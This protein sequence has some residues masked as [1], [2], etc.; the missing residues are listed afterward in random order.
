MAELIESPLKVAEDHYLLRIKLDKKLHALPGQFINIR[1]SDSTDPL[2]RRPF[3]IFNQNEEILE[4]IIQVVGRGTTLLAGR[5]KGPIDI[6]GPLGK[7]FTLLE[8]GSAL[9]V[10]GGVGNAPLY[11][12]ARALKDRGVSVTCLYGA[13]AKKYI[14]CAKNFG[15]TADIFKVATDDGSTGH[16]GFITE[17]MQ[18]MLKESSY[19]M[20]YTCGPTPMMA[21][22]AGLCEG[23]IPLEVSLENYFGCGIGLCAGCTVE[24]DDGFKRAC[25]DGPVM[26]GSYL[27]WETLSH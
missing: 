14:Y 2:V 5:E 18:E 26:D 10:G 12:L 4:I 23:R 25:I 3:S 6:L 1:I 11:Y 16:R 27:K 22:V 9:L 15:T 13:R 7:G 19:N 17:L 20:V 21:G 24:T 8:K